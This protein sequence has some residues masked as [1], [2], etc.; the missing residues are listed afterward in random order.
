MLGDL[1]YKRITITY[2]TQEIEKLVSSEL[3]VF[4]KNVELLTLEAEIS[5]HYH[6]QP[7]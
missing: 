5:R 2:S 3:R 1:E 6:T 4:G 7:K